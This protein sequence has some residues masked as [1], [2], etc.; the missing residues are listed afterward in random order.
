MKRGDVLDEM[1][2][3]QPA[4]QPK[5][6]AAAKADDAGTSGDKDRVAKIRAA[7]RERK[8]Q[9][10]TEGVSGDEGISVLTSLREE[11][12]THL[13]LYKHYLTIA[14][15]FNLFYYAVT[16]GVVSYALSG[17]LWRSFALTFPM[18][19][20]FFFALVFWEAWRVFEKAE[21]DVKNIARSLGCERDEV[22]IL[23]QILKYSFY[24]YCFNFCALLILFIGL[25]LLLIDN[26]LF[27]WLSLQLLMILL[28]H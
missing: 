2:K 26:L 5:E 16:G 24:M 1:E 4:S 6:Q 22:N 28:R 3:P 20:S 27:G 8:A 14:A 23:T 9:G 25:L 18:L 19:M 10:D 15:S 13:D 12:K 21:K 7:L 11:Y 17:E